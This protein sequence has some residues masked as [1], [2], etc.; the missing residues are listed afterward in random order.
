MNR[1]MFLGALL[2]LAACKEPLQSPQVAPE[3]VM[4]SKMSPAGA[5]IEASI[6]ANNPNKVELSASGMQSKVTIGGKPDVAKALVTSALT[7][8]ASQRIKLKLPIK[9]EW[10]NP[11]AIAAL[12]DTKQ[13]APYTVEGTVEFSSREGTVKTPFVINGVMTAEELAGA[14]GR[15]VEKPAEKPAAKGDGGASPSTSASAKPR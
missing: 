4:I 10:T 7:L 12:A 14:A 8:P 13:P 11:A 15:P 2:L 5:E 9:V 1:A 3:G 6:N